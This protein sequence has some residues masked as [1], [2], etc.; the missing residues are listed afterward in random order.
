M[1]ADISTRTTIGSGRFGTALGRVHTGRLW[2]VIAL[3]LLIMA[4]SVAPAFAGAVTIQGVGD[5]MMATIDE[6]TFFE[7]PLTA[8][9][10]T[11]DSLTWFVQQWM[12]TVT[13]SMMAIPGP[14]VVFRYTPPADYYTDDMFMTNVG[15]ASV[16]D[17][18][19]GSDS[20]DFYVTVNPVE[21]LPEI[22]QGAFYPTSTSEDV[23]TSFT[24][25]ASDADGDPLMW[26]VSSQ[27]ANGFVSGGAAGP[28]LTVDYTPDANYN[29]LDTFEITVSDGDDTATIL[30]DMWVSPVNDAPTAMDAFGWGSEE[31]LMIGYL[32]VDAFDADY[33]PL[34]VASF[35]SVYG[36]LVVPPGGSI[37]Q[38][39]PEG[40][41]TVYSDGTYQF[42][43][44]LDGWGLW[45]HTI[46]YTVTDET[47]NASAFLV[48]DID[49]VEDVP[50]IAEGDSITA[51][52]AEE[53]QWDS[54]LSAYD[55]DGDTLFWSVTTGASGGVVNIDPTGDTIAVSYL[56]DPG[57]YGPDYFEVTVDDGDGDTDTI[58]VD[59]AVD[60]E[61]DMPAFSLL[62]DVN[63]L[64]DCADE[65]VAG[66]AYDIDPGDAFESGQVLA[67]AL[68]ND[69]SELFDVQ[70]E[71]AA[72]GTL[73]FTAAANANGT[74]HV[75]VTLVDD[76]AY[77]AGTAL[78]TVEQYF[79][80]NIASVIDPPTAVADSYTVNEDSTL[81]VSAPGV[82]L[83]DINE[84]AQPMV[85]VIDTY[86]VH[87]ALFF[88]ANGSFFY[89]PDTNYH[90][91][92]PFT[93][94][95]TDGVTPS[96][97]VSA[98]ITVNS[99]NDV[100]V[101]TEGGALN[102]GTAEDTAQL[103]TLSATDADLD[104][105]VWSIDTAALHGTASVDA[106]GLVTYTPTTDFFG[107]DVFTV[108]VSDGNGGVATTVVNVAVSPSAESLAVSY[109]IPEDSPTILKFFGEV[110][111]TT[112]NPP[113]HA[114]IFE[115]NTQWIDW[116]AR[117]GGLLYPLSSFQYAPVA[118][119]FGTDIFT[120]TLD[121]S[122]ATVTLNITPVNDAPRNIS[123]SNASIPEDI[124]VGSLVGTLSAVDPDS[125]LFTYSL[126]GGDTNAFAL[127]GEQIHTK[128]GFDYDTRSS[129]T[130]T[131]RADD[132]AGGV[133]DKAI[134]INV[135]N[136]DEPPIVVGEIF[137]VVE[138]STLSGDVSPNDFD[139]D[140]APV[141][142]MLSTA[143]SHATSFNFDNGPGTFTYTP[144]A[145][146]SG[147][148]SFTY[149]VIS[150]TQSTDGTVTVNVTNVND[151]PVASLAAPGISN[152]GVVY[153]DT[154]YISD[155]SVLANDTD[156]DGDT[157][158]AALSTPPAHGTFVLFA[159]GYFL[160]AP[161]ANYTG[162]DSFTYRAFDGG[163]YSDYVT[164]SIWVTAVD[165]EPAI[166]QGSSASMSTPEDT[167]D[168]ITLDA[169]D[170]DAGSTLT[171]SL[172]NEA[173]HGEVSVAGTG[174]SKVVGY[175]PD[176]DYHGL[177]A[178]NVI[179]EDETGRSDTILVR[180][181]VSTVNDAP[182]AL[183]D[184]MTVAEDT[185][186]SVAAPGVLANDDD[187]DGDGLTAV[188]DVAP[189]GAAFNL[190]PDGSYTYS[191]DPDY[192][193]PVTFTYHATD[194]GAD[195][196]VATVT[197]DV[198]PVND[199]P[200]D[201]ALTGDAVDE[202]AAA[203]SVVGAFTATDV[204]SS[205]FTYAIVGVSDA[206]EIVGGELRTLRP[207][208]HE[209]EESIDITVR[210]DDGTGGIYDAAFTIWVNDVDEAP[211]TAADSLDAVE[212]TE[213]V[214][215]AAG[216]LGNDADPEGTAIEASLVA[217]PAHGAM[218]LAA[219]GSLSYMPEPNF[220][221]DDAF[222]YQATDGGLYSPVT[223]VT[224]HVAGVNDA[225]VTGS[226]TYATDEDVVLVVAAPGLYEN[227]SDIEDDAL[228]ASAVRTPAHGSV[229]F[230]ADGA[231]DYSPARGWSGTDSFTYRT[232][233][234]AAY[235]NVSTV[236][237]TVRSIDTAV[238]EVEGE[239]RL[240]TAVE[241]SKA[242]FADGADTVVIATSE[243]WPDALGGSALA[244]AVD[245]PI[246][247]TKPQML[248]SAVLAEIR[249]LGA[250]SAYVLGGERAVSASVLNALNA[251]L[252]GDVV[253][254]G[255]ANRNQTAELVAE[256]TVA[257][258][259]GA[260]G[261]AFLA[262]GTNFPDALAASPLAAYKKWPI[263]LSSDDGVSDATKAAMT[264]AGINRIIILGSDA[265]ISQ[266]TE[267]DL[268]TSGFDTERV[269]GV[270][271]YATAVSAADYGVRLGLS[272]SGLA[273]ATGQNFPDGLSGGVLAA[274]R[275]AVMLLNPSEVL[276]PA[277]HDAVRDN[278]DSI[279]D[280]YYLGG[281]NAV[282]QGVRDDIAGL[283][284]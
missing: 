200:T 191:P 213:L 199:A 241:V 211:V 243:N 99:V 100:P 87:G 240:L 210:A 201:I 98:N 276:H 90:G 212:D 278:R 107:A 166:T 175:T 234:G 238:H 196:P 260:D 21:D 30:I 154:T 224:I 19:T 72:D 82:T 189:A 228:V 192:N 131:V 18:S 123:L 111:A 184:A 216:I 10:A 63:V 176:A 3:A 80:I 77:G 188:L 263:Y 37:T 22:A 231:F 245:G 69:A 43:P 12:P 198:T 88:F 110:V 4:F 257:L 143:P 15:Y 33:D 217:G 84:D 237:I 89:T 67:F 135:T 173:A 253:R 283:L 17:S 96:A 125:S 60:P 153:E 239:N 221:G 280:V 269:S 177:D 251:A 264:S 194:G 55:G 57:F 179:V 53:T 157:L 124:S 258:T 116:D 31:G 51:S 159:N 102:I 279:D 277:V 233:D 74:A 151:A 206:F 85:C 246:L 79:D 61:N 52:T 42:I 26:W 180:V 146:F 164:N 165:D 20:I 225:P 141:L 163:A 138:E 218:A 168:S 40:S 94:H 97:P 62:G 36:T 8:T 86:P 249:R 28:D 254:L 93:Y 108:K 223:T 101:I 204:D 119:Y 140:S 187:V 183:D 6:D 121:S 5:S 209:A 32:L 174:T 58:A 255:G 162:P 27:P 29:G 127:V 273:M 104:G 271:R 266:A 44:S 139:V 45:Y 113:G 186:L 41:M 244:G 250:T 270:D 262:R 47:D 16:F 193:G 152:P 13:P 222:T 229:T 169:T 214:I 142:W 39:T 226:D 48:I 134:A 220:F 282:S 49:P 147:T 129:Y 248:D 91:S 70:P 275:G 267:A 83:N 158:I 34:R 155:W 65:T 274:K 172:G 130:V 126:V 35:S 14:T 215:D 59:I 24:L 236:T 230:G 167:A 181:N 256:E 133:F 161:A 235:S 115:V 145:D 268:V 114:S 75:T 105:I 68:T 9:D 197:I 117:P 156:V 23:P 208:D 227:D 185:P 38:D 171:W 50:V 272:W 25:N 136:V 11:G 103:F 160:Y 232:F 178:F 112:V 66:Q 281:T 144:E 203:S 195:S 76:D 92:D 78:S 149:H 219:D 148:D 170:P 182:T 71:I 261:M 202:N 54:T 205:V 46:E 109:T 247:L 265:A 122:P 128:T 95:V 64:E 106:A 207:L 242:A 150:G 1:N 252:S 259:G 118:D 7:I 284:R 120:V 2:A 132:L 81:M 56:P 190:N 73:T 137:S